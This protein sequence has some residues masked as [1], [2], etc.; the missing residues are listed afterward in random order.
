MPPSGGR[1]RQ[2]DADELDAA[3]GRWLLNQFSAGR[4][5]AGQLAVAID[6]TSL[7]GAV[8]EDGQALKLLAAMTHDGGAVVAQREVAA[9]S[10]EIAAVQP[11]LASTDLDGAV[12]TADALTR[13]TRARPH[14]G[15]RPRAPTP[16]SA[17]RATSP[18]SNRASPASTRPRFPP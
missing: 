4:V 16:S 7:R 2:V 12:V 17:S 13:P 11:L 18:A 15:Q 3:V 9:A 14:P 5:D 10:N 1:S 8:H 6:G